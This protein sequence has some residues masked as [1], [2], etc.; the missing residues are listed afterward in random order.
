M[1]GGAADAELSYD[2][3]IEVLP[4]TWEIDPAE[5][6][7]AA[8][9]EDA[10]AWLRCDRKPLSIAIVQTDEGLVYQGSYVGREGDE[11]QSLIRSHRFAILLKYDN[12]ERTTPDGE[13]VEWYLLM[14][15]RDRHYWVRADWLRTQ[16]GAR[17]AMFRRCPEDGPIS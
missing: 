17:T 1:S 10:V 2:E 15:D 16:P 13:L 3:I 11:H 8:L 5:L 9:E 7:P 6:D 12:E 4:G 14:P